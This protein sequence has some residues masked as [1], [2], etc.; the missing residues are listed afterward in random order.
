MFPCTSFNIVSFYQTLNTR[1]EEVQKT[2]REIPRKTP[3]QESKLKKVLAQWDALWHSSRLYVER[4]KC[5]EILLSSL[6]DVTNNVSEIEHKLATYTHMPSEIK[7]LQK[8][9]EELL[10]LQ[11]KATAQQHM[12]N[13][14]SEDAHNARKVVEES[15]KHKGPYDDLN[16]LDSDITRLNNR[17][18]N[19]IS[20]L[21]D[22]YE[23]RNHGYLT[24][25]ICSTC[26][27]SLIF[28]F[29]VAQ[30]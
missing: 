7:P 8:V 11:S 24:N 3:Q 15:R 27:T 6:D 9:H 21:S 16:R 23:C 19:L 20:Q 17:W 25:G 13:Q 12:I 29:Q 14:L 30:L 26:I 10:V 28:H 2:F 5:I 22:R 1:V 4:L 18:S